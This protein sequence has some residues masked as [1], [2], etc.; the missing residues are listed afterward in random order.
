MNNK[1]K[2]MYKFV[3]NW[4]RYIKNIKKL[5]LKSNNFDIILNLTVLAEKSSQSLYL[6]GF[7]SFL[8]MR[9][10]NILKNSYFKMLKKFIFIL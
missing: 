9:T 7:E 5:L 10:F 3:N 8:N 1:Y 2:K 6:C 4:V